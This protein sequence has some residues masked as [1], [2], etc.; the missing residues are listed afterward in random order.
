MPKG[1]STNS[2]PS[3][4]IPYTQND[5]RRIDLGVDYATKTTFACTKL[6]TLKSGLQVIESS[7]HYDA[8]KKGK[9]KTDSEYCDML[10]EFIGQDRVTAVYVDPSASSFI[11]ALRRVPKRM[12][13]V[14]TADNAVLDGIRVTMNQLTKEKVVIQDNKSNAPL[15]DE[16]A[17]YVWDEKKEDDL[18]KKINDHHVDALRYVVYSL[19]KRGSSQGTVHLPEGL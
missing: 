9:Q 11:V 12:F 17:D 13:H 5:I 15:L 16:L 7:L 6:V 18:P 4:K 3:K 1:K 19:N 10:L 8:K 14:R 2:T